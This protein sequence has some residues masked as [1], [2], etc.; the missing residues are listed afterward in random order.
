MFVSGLVGCLYQTA[1]LKMYESIWKRMR[2][3]CNSQRWW[4]TP[5]KQFYGYNRSDMLMNSQRLWQHAWVQTRQGFNAEKGKLTQSLTLIQEIIYIWYLL[6]K[7]KSIFLNGRSLVMLTILPNK[8]QTPYGFECFW[9][10][11]Y[12]LSYC[13]LL[14]LL[15]AL[16]FTFLGCCW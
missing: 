16:I 15:F 11:W 1:H 6:W 2:E 7:R 13:L 8:K 12:I 3:Y 9:F 5:R 14:L 10:V 4:I